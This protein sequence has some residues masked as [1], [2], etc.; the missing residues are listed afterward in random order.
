MCTKL[1]ICSTHKTN[2][3][4]MPDDDHNPSLMHFQKKKLNT[5]QELAGK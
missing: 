1:F 3:F 5:S 2:N 4:A